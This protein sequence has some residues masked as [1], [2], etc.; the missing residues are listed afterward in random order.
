ML[1]D[2]LKE[3]PANKSGS[4]K[5]RACDDGAWRFQRCFCIGQ[6]FFVGNPLF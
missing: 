2:E 6:L 3:I 4:W 5:G 1:E